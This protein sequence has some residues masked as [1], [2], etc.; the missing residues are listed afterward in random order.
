MSERAK[1]PASLDDALLHSRLSRRQLLRRSVVFGLSVPAIGSLLAACGSDDDDDEPTEAPD[2]SG[3]GATATMAAPAD[4]ETE[5]EDEPTAEEEPDATEGDAEE[6]SDDEPAVGG[7]GE[8]VRGGTLR[9][10]LTGDLGTFDTQAVTQSV[11][12]YVTWHI[13][14]HLFTYDEDMQIAPELADTYE[15]SEDSLTHT[16]TVRE[17]MFHNGNPMTAEDVVASIERWRQIAGTAGDLEDIS[18]SLTAVDDRTVEWELSRPFG[19]LTT[20]LARQNAG[21]VIFP[22]EIMEKIGTEPLTDYADF[23]GTGTYQFVEH[24]PDRHIHLRRFE[25]YVNRDEPTSG[26]AGFK[27]QY[28]DEIFFIPVTD[29]AA[30]V[31]GVR[32]GDYQY[33]DALAPIQFAALESDPAVTLE[34]T[35][36]PSWGAFVFNCAEGICSG[37]E[38]TPGQL[39]RQAILA[40]LNMEEIAL[41]AYGEGWF[42]LHPSISFEGL[43]WETEAGGEFYNQGDPDRARELLEEAGYNGEPIIWM[44][45]REYQDHYDTT[46]LAVQQLEDAGITI[47]LQLYDWATVNERRLDPALWHMMTTGHTFR[48]D[49]IQLSGIASAETYGFWGSPAIEELRVPFTAEHEF[50]VRFGIWED[51]QTLFY[52]AVPKMKVADQSGFHAMSANLRGWDPA[53][54]IQAK[55]WNEWFEE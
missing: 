18:V 53:V 35:P 38:G 43:P 45:T 20:V 21:C 31:A 49:P 1:D 22:K 7:P 25:E 46:V 19:I 48:A 5:A 52:H 39:I 34:M 23:I 51:I 27:N 16:I 50:E 44:T 30:A 6:T 12:G 36:S 37:Y 47:D 32:A 9:A 13:W 2:T 28:F 14:E 8:G 26:Y 42:R 10:T 33:V 55:H 24:Q 17:A 29:E 4:E 40:A 54:Q 3:G 11:V 41:G 15:V